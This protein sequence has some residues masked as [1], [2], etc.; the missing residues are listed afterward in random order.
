MTIR[1][2]RFRRS[3]EPIEIEHDAKHYV[4]VVYIKGTEWS[5]TMSGHTGEVGWRM[6]QLGWLVVTQ[7]G[8]GNLLDLD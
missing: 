2:P 8:F 1:E 4:K 6:C 5:L 3:V 7:I